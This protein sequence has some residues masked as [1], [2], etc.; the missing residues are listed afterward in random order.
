MSARL[1]RWIC[2]G[3]ALSALCTPAPPAHAA[4]AAPAAPRPEGRTLSA[5][6]TDLQQR[7]RAAEEATETYNATEEKLKEQRAKA[8]DLNRKLIQAR[9]SLRDSR[10]DAGRFA[11][12]Q[13]QGATG[14]SPY[15]RL[16]LARD[17]QR[18]L[19]QSHVIQR[20]AAGRAAAIERLT[21]GEKRARELADAARRAL[22]AQS[23]LAARQKK[24]RDEVGGRLKEVHELLAALTPDQLA[25]LRAAEDAGTARAQE[26][27][28]ASGAL[29]GSPATRAPSPRGDKALD[30]AVRQI[31]RPYE[32][33]TAGPDTY[34]CSGLTSKAWR[35]AGRAIPRT[36]QEQW[37]KLR[38]VPLSKL[39][40]GDLVVYFPKATHVAMYLGDGR[41]VHA[42]RPGARVKVS[43]IAANPVLGAV[44]PDPK[45][46]PLSGY[47][48]PE[49]P[50]GATSGSDLGYGGDQAP[51]ATDSR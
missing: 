48:P 29:G 44:R 41:V 36:S 8:A 26:E 6:L 22:A 43:P 33:G 20:V 11:R 1:L 3:A 10:G 47:T 46:R 14:L 30:F 25:A 34:D 51:D 42:P 5:L 31:G 49:L 2:T 32:W 45:S 17:P 27:F 16:L 12:Q 21:G 9:A 7:Y 35:H 23:A 37:A 13:Y 40:P 4:P 28:V 24:Q 19:D 50:E 39:R 18:A 38:R 15:V